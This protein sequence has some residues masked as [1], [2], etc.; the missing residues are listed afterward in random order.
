MTLTDINRG[1][2]LKHLEI[3]NGHVFS[4]VMNNYW[5]TNY[6]AAQGGDF[7]FRYYITSGKELAREGLSRFDADTRAPVFAYALLSTYAAPVT[8]EGK[9]LPAAQGSLMTLA[10]PNL[11][12]V[13]FK[14]AEDGDG[15]ILRLKEVAGR[16]G[17]T[18]V[19]LPLLRIAEAYLC[20]GVEAV[21]HKL[22]STQT[23]VRV[24]Y[25]ANRYVT[26]RLKAA[27]AVRRW[28]SAER[29]LPGLCSTR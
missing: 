10:A 12:F 28:P 27:G 5:M 8:G 20:N 14:Q 19:S 9:P 16:S 21:Q 2:W 3:K 4:Y 15:Y 26:V 6:K 13:A 29:R 23:S 17:E 22:P 11:E 1:K 18:E 7:S 24:P 25:S